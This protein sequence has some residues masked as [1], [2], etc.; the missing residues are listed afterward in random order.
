MVEQ[1]GK[2][3]VFHKYVTKPSFEVFCFL[4]FSLWLSKCLKGKQVKESFYLNSLNKFK[5]RRWLKMAGLLVAC[6]A[7][8]FAQT[9]SGDLVGTVYDATGATVPNATVMATNVATSKSLTETTSG[10]GS[11]RFPNLLVGTYNLSVSAPGFSKAEVKN[12]SVDLNKASTA[13]VTLQV[14]KGSDSV[15]VTSA[16]AVIDTS[17]ATI[18]GTFDS[19]MMT[20]LPSASSGSGVLNLSLLQPG[21]ATSGSVGTGSGPSVGGQRPANNSFTIEGIDNNGRSTTGPVVFVPNDAV[22]EFTMQQNQ[23]SPE[24]GHSSGGQFNQVIKSGSNAFH[25]SAFEYFENRNLNAADNLSSVSGNPLHPRF[26]DNRFGGTVGGPIKKNKLF[27]FVDYEYNP[28][29]NSASAGQI[30]APTAAGY[31]ALG[32]ISGISKT[33]LAILQQYLGTAPTALSAA[34]AGGYPVVGPTYEAGNPTSYN[35]AGVPTG[36]HTGVSIPIGQISFNPPSFTNNEYAVASADYNLSSTDSLRGRFILNR[37]GSIDTNG[38][39]ASFFTTNPNNSYLATFTEFH[40]FSANLVNEFRFGYNRNNAFTSVPNTPF[41]G[42]DVFPNITLNEL[43]V[44]VGPDPNGPQGGIQNI[45]E[46]TDNV[47]YTKGRH[48]FKFGFD[49][50]DSISPQVFTQRSRGDY[51]WNYLSDYLFDYYP[52]YLAQRSI[53]GKTYYGNNYLFGFYANDTWKIRPNLTINLGLRYEYQTVPLGEREQSLNAAASVPGLIN[54]TAPQPQGNAFMPRIGVAYSPGTSGKTSVRAGFGINY[55]I[56]RDNLGLNTAVPQFSSVVDVTGAVSSSGV[57]LQGFLA[58]GGISP[59]SIPAN[60]TPAQLRAETGGYLPNAERPKSFQWNA[61]VQHVFKENYT[62]DVRYVGTRGLH[63]TVQDQLNRQPVV[64]ASDALPVYYTAPSQTTLNSLTN[65][66]ANLNTIY[67]NG[68]YLVPAYAN[69]GFTGILTSYQPWGDSTYHGLSTSVTRRFNNGLQ[70]IGAYTWSH[71]IDD[72]T[73][74][75]FSTYTTPRRPQDARNIAADKASSALDHR[76]RLTFESIYDLPFFKKSNWVMKNL[77]GNWEIA[78]IY[79]YQTGTL[80]TVQSGLDSNLNGDT[81]GDRTIVNPLGNPTI[82]SGTTA[83]QNS[84]GQTVAYLVNNTAAGYIVAPKGT[85]ANG[86]R[87]TEHFNPIDDI[88]LS[89]AKRINI[90]E[91]YN[92]QFSMRASNIFNHPQ[93]TGGN[94]NDIAPVGQTGAGVHNALIPTSSLFGQYT[95]VLS[96]NPRFLQLAL[97]FI[98]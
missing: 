48:S 79:T 73:A 77:V 26:D 4:R 19:Q 29:G 13:N 78:P 25:G 82:G 16:A 20:E 59:S 32:G 7:A 35:A 21:V 96:S 24:F 9:T 76:Q 72:S 53:G 17:T 94:L 6:C 44:N 61:G 68:G 85:L 50:Q 33:N 15:E 67:G 14:G 65:T 70:F 22:A 42:L 31:S 56:I 75:V 91:K 54:F 49:G 66:L 64:N 10:S 63:L 8:S 30:F 28:I 12:I 23:F 88:D 74:D 46:L 90:T 39:P 37:S 58:N 60:P 87:N 92:L 97:K 1:G 34:A 41:P 80:V 51:E 3:S 52:D 89:F 86:G 11:Y 43:N 27:F 83:L 45:Y 18:A 2:L 40:N 93:Y 62:L 81:A 98:F 55:D 5:S 69:A 57:P 95:Q 47:S 38:Y 36:G 84:A 71:A